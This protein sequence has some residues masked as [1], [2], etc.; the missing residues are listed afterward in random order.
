MVN[1]FSSDTS[2]MWNWVSF[3]LC[4]STNRQEKFFFS[5]FRQLLAIFRCFSTIYN[6]WL[7]IIGIC[8]ISHWT[9]K[10]WCKDN[11]QR[12]LSNLEL[13]SGLIFGGIK[14]RKNKNYISPDCVSLI[15]EMLS[16]NFAPGPS[17]GCETSLMR[18]LQRTARR[19]IVH[20]D[21]YVILTIGSSQFSFFYGKLLNFMVLDVFMVFFFFFQNF[22][23]ILPRRSDDGRRVQT[24]V[25]NNRVPGETNRSWPRPWRGLCRGKTHRYSAPPSHL[26]PTETFCEYKKE[27]SLR[28]RVLVRW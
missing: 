27:R 17:H 20:R 13:N 16:R 24:V 6:S 2:S 26:L 3:R 11:L 12:L 28:C 15:T 8:E 23:H 4:L 1:N 10:S 21:F 18:N 22:Y 7:A 5:I 19:R 25:Y 9:R 14:M